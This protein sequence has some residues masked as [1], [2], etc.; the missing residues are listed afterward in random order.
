MHLGYK[1]I[2][3]ITVGNQSNPGCGYQLLE[4]INQIGYFDLNPF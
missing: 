4:G 1:I 2:T 3:H